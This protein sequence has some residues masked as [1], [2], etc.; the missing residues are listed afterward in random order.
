MNKFHKHNCRT[1]YIPEA[2]DLEGAFHSIKGLD[3]DGLKRRA[4]EVGGTHEYVDTVTDIDLKVFIIQNSLSDEHILFKDIRKDII[5]GVD[6]QDLIQKRDYCKAMMREGK[7]IQWCPKIAK[8]TL[9]DYKPV[10]LPPPKTVL[11]KKHILMTDPSTTIR[12][13]RKDMDDYENKKYSL[14]I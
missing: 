5:K 1:L 6:Q 8:P 4:L 9:E 12:Q 3:S 11:D 13:M 14:V 2:M 10:V 7:R